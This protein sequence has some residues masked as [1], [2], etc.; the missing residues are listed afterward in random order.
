MFGDPLQ[1]KSGLLLQ[2]WIVP[3]LALPGH[4][5]PHFGLVIEQSNESMKPAPAGA[6][7]TADI[8]F[9]KNVE[10]GPRK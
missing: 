8:F 10:G 9:K 4:V 1:W 2:A 7:E 6:G 5:G 3:L